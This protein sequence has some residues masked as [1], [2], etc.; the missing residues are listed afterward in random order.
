MTFHHKEKIGDYSLNNV[1]KTKRSLLFCHLCIRHSEEAPF[2]IRRTCHCLM[3]RW[4]KQITM[5]WW[6]R[7]QVRILSGC[8]F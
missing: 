4:L 2:S 8:R 3:S 5:L 7:D 1:C 6:R